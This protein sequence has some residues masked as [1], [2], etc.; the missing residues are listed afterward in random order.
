MSSALVNSAWFLSL[1][2]SFVHL[3][4]LSREKVECFYLIYDIWDIYE[5]PSGFF[6]SCCFRF[7]RRALC[8]CFGFGF[9]FGFGFTHGGCAIHSAM[10]VVLELFTSALALIQSTDAILCVQVAFAREFVIIC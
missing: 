5:T 8:H 6:I 2:H 1:G 4:K 7:L 3:L 9:D 10:A